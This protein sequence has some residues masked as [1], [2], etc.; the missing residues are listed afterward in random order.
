L[1]R[2]TVAQHLET[3]L[4]VAG[5]ELRPNTHVAYDY[6]IRCFLLPAF[7][8]VRIQRVTPQIVARQFADWKTGGQFSGKTLLN[9][10]RTF[11]RSLVVA[12]QWGLIGTNP[13][14]AVEA[15]RAVR[16][17]PE[18]WSPAEA[19]AF[20]GA[21]E[22][23]RW[24]STLF[25]LLMG[26]GCRIGEVL[27]AR[28]ED[29]DRDARTLSIRGTLVRIQGEYLEGEPKTRAGRRAICLPNFADSVLRSWRPAQLEQ[30]LRAGDAWQDTGRIITLPDGASPLHGKAYNAFKGACDAAGVPKTRIHDLRHLHASLLLAGGLPLPAVS[31]RLGHASTAVT[32]TIYSH[33]LKGSD[34][35][36]ANS[37]QEAIAG[38]L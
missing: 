17:V 24:D 20:L 19:S 11:H 22:M 28:W 7:G 26:T 12:R 2:V 13:L 15:P 37:I 4:A 35:V 5:A 31:A 10:F 29:F 32:A 14:D 8:P 38:R 16:V 3:W 21:A 36:A 6:A 25:V 1:S 27:A 18:I 34:I 9:V 23:G 33:A 30:R